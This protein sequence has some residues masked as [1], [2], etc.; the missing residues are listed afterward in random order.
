MNDVGLEGADEGAEFAVGGGVAERVE[1]ADEAGDGVSGDGVAG[2]G[3]EAV[4]AVEEGALGAEDGP[5]GEVEFVAEGG[6]ALAGEDGVFLGAAE[7][8][9]G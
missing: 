1:F 9:P 2:G 3:A 5:E 8:E 6:L 7:D 4:D